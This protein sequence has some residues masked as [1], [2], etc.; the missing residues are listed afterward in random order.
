MPASVDPAPRT[1]YH[2]Q[3][4]VN[5][6]GPSRT[7]FLLGGQAETDNIADL[8]RLDIA[9]PEGDLAR[10]SVD[11]G[12]SWQVQYAFYDGRGDL[13]ATTDA[14]GT[15][16]A[17]YR[18]DPFGVRLDAA[19]YSYGTRDEAF[20]A[21]P[22]ALSNP[23]AEPAGW[24]ASEAACLEEIELSYLWDQEGNPFSEIRRYTG[25][26]S[27]TTTNAFNEGN[28]LTGKTD[29]SGRVYSFFYD[30]RG[31]LV[32]T[33]YPTTSATFSFKTINPAGWL[34][35]VVNRHGT[36]TTP[37]GK[38]AGTAPSS[39][40]ADPTPLADYTY[41]YFQDGQKNTQ[42]AKVGAGSTQ[43]TTYAYDPV[44]RLETVVF[45]DAT[46]RRY[47]FDL[48]SNRSRWNTSTTGDC[49]SGSAGATYSYAA[50]KLDQLGSVT[51]GTA[52]TNYTYDGDGDVTARGSDTFGWDV[53]GRLAGST[54]PG[55]T[56]GYEF[57]PAGFRHKRTVVT[58][59]LGAVLESQP[60]SY[61]RLDETA[62]T[63]AVD[64]VAAK[65]GTYSGGY[66]LNQAGA[67]SG[68]G[69]S[70]PGI[71]LNGSTGW[72]TTPV[73]LATTQLAH[74]SLEAWVK[75]AAAPTSTR[76]IA[77]ITNSIK[78]QLLNT[79][80]VQASYLDGAGVT[81]SVLASSITTGVWHHL[82]VLYDGSQL[83]VYIDGL[84]SNAGVL[85]APAGNANTFG[86]G[87]T[88]SSSNWFNGQIDEV[89][90][91][92]RAL[93]VAEVLDHKNRG[94]QA[95]ASTSV[96][97]RFGGLEESDS[98][99]PLPTITQADVNAPD[100]SD[101]VHDSEDPVSFSTATTF[102]YY[103]G[104]GDLAIEADPAGS[105]LATH[106]YDPF[107]TPLDSS[108]DNN[109]PVAAAGSTERYTGAW[110]KKL[111]TSTNL[112]EMGARPY[113]PALGRF[114]A[115]DPILG[116]SLNSYDYAGQDPINSY[117]LD[118]TVTAPC[119][120]RV[121]S[122]DCASGSAWLAIP[123]GAP[124]SVRDRRRHRTAVRG[125]RHE[126]RPP[127]GVR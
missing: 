66:T 107:G 115:T 88:S 91:Y 80:Q 108:V 68:S 53:R 19:A 43:T 112:V 78:L 94:L 25:T 3:L 9:G 6:M 8:A 71:S 106:T 89:A 105:T 4:G 57:D 73:T 118:G 10:F 86:I 100:G 76:T 60:A 69:D 65:N 29:Y 117:D 44:G 102:L 111:D 124:A 110:D 74:F 7:D 13:A 119:P 67:L 93:T 21:R 50:T 27:R 62:G 97:E 41:T 121:R 36:L 56:V 5:A 126:R 55:R 84:Q 26:Y 82:V 75:I 23:N 14:V 77:G 51:A 37:T 127:R 12:G 46:S 49:S 47:C 87:N 1:A 48:D 81:R 79:R 38:A 70:D 52:T 11:A 83:R 61:W 28:Q 15:R 20:T 125:R 72:V 30:S 39:A 17:S 54:V 99:S 101:I 22:I 90:L 120:G 32:G 123:A 113:D 96:Y 35:S 24:L 45:P 59:Y 64:R 104:H 58:G 63:T 116:G 2:A 34:D 33:D 92:T 40:P 18:Y 122:Y 95:P 85:P 114:Y 16:T 42:A 109:T 103:N 31:N 98:A